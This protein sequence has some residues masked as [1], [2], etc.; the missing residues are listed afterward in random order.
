MNPINPYIFFDGDCA[1]ALRFYERVLKGKIGMLM[2]EDEMPGAK[3]LS[4]RK[5]RIMHAR[6]EAA[7]GILLASDWM[8]ERPFE[9]K[10]GFYVSVEFPAKEEAQ[11]VF[12]ALAEGGQVN[13]P[14]ADT[15]WSQGFGMLVDK[16]GTPWMINGPRK[17]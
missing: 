12:E 5:P 16:Y 1:D 15:F 8:A 14:F 6:L 11:R 13:L 10:Q 17:P 9:R 3:P 7:G 2:R 4:G